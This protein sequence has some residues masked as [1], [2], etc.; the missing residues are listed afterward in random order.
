[1]IEQALD[2]GLTVFI[3][4]VIALL[5]VSIFGV[6]SCESLA[7]QTALQLREAINIVANDDFPTYSPSD[8]NYDEPS[9]SLYYETVPIRLCQKH[10]TYS[11][12][13]AFLG[14]GM[15]EWQIYY[16]HFPEMGGGAW[17]EAYPWS[18]GA[19]STFVF[20]AA[21]R[22]AEVAKGL[23][24]YLVGTY[25]AYK[26]TKAGIKLLFKGRDFGFLTWLTKRNTFRQMLVEGLSNSFSE[27]K[28]TGRSL[29]IIVDKLGNR[30][31]HYLLRFLGDH[32]PDS[33]GWVGTLWD[34]GTKTVRYMGT[35]DPVTGNVRLAI[36]DVD[37]PEKMVVTEYD[38]TYGGYVD[39]V[40]EYGVRYTDPGPFDPSRADWNDIQIVDPGQAVDPG[41]VKPTYNPRKVM[42]ELHDALIEAG[43]TDKAN[44]IDEMF[45][46][47]NPGVL[48]DDV[49]KL[50]WIQKISN[51][52]TK[53]VD[54]MKNYL[55]GKWYLADK[56]TPQTGD[57]IYRRT[58]AMW[59]LVQVTD[60]ADPLFPT[61][62]S[63]R[64]KV[65]KLLLEAK[66]LDFKNKI[67]FYAERFGIGIG[68]DVSAEDAV[69]VINRLWQEEG[70]GLVFYHA[71]DLTNV[72]VRAS[73]LIV[74]DPAKSIDDIL[75]EIKNLDHYDEYF[76]FFEDR[77]IGGEPMGVRQIID[78]LKQLWAASG[79]NED[80]FRR[81]V[82]D[83]RLQHLVKGIDLV[84]GG[85]VVDDATKE[86][87]ENQLQMIYGV[88]S[89]DFNAFP[90]PTWKVFATRY[91]SKQLKKMVFID[92][93]ALVAPNSWFAKGLILTHMT[94]RCMGNSLCV[95]SQAAEYESPYYLSENATEY[96]VKSWRPIEPW[97]HLLG[98]QAALQNVP[99]HPRF[100]VVSP[101]FAVAK[102][103]KTNL[104]GQPTIF[105]H[106][107][108]VDMEGKRSNYCYADA[109]LINTYT[110][111]W[112][113]ADILTI[114]EVVLS[115]G[116]RAAEKGL[117]AT[118][119]QTLGKWSMFDPVTLGQTLAEAAISWPG[120]PYTSLNYTDIHESGTYSEPFKDLEESLMKQFGG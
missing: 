63:L 61:A 119:K 96:S 89:K 27:F 76:S 37:I 11:Y 35:E 18:G 85:A 42:T 40:K 34:D 106:P 43:Q 83:F 10:G 31:A 68:V 120:Y 4:I 92:G 28:G 16:E 19:A 58:D 77:M 82:E 93:T 1:M 52:V 108:K 90:V 113:A 111:I 36:K 104:D 53:R 14:G 17:N 78:N 71:S 47:A 33:L 109:D 5:F 112:G 60:P 110:A 94:E 25:Y 20:W 65:I 56:L 41:Y 74:I 9:R 69:K 7:N 84:D 97:K 6:P 95:Y 45:D 99:P 59:R 24:K 30:D 57:E 98:W 87:L 73:D 75:A 2:L 105:V 102:V 86:L 54:R 103:W 72:F 49:K 23:A 107:I 22:G 79:G 101:C 80:T 3:F 26:A 88:F 15:P 51:A 48:Q 114:V 66:D 12:I 38:S 55:K 91:A 13:S 118:V 62:Q 46:L 115:F 81:F 8:P 64:E 32:A 39:K 44:F 29:Q 21:F 67:K 116:T 100:Y 70:G 117:K 50:S